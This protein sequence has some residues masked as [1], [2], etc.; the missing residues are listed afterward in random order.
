MFFGAHIYVL[1]V[2]IVVNTVNENINAA[3]KVHILTPTSLPV[4]PFL[5]FSTVAFWNAC[6]SSFV[7]S[8]HVLL[9]RMLDL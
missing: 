1:H 4:Y 5:K 7:A 9:N 8:F 6:K 3:G 2:P